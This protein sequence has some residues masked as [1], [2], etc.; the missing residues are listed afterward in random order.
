MTVD[1]CLPDESSVNTTAVSSVSIV[2]C[3][4]YILQQFDYCNVVQLDWKDAS[5]SVIQNTNANA[6]TCFYF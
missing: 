4:Y 1:Y 3:V 5:Y 2:L 6:P